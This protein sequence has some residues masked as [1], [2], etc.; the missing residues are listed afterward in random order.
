MENNTPVII[1]LID[2]GYD[3]STYR[4]EPLRMAIKNDNREVIQKLLDKGV[5]PNADGSQGYISAIKEG[6]LEIIKL[7]INKEPPTLAILSV[8]KN[9][10]NTEI[11]QE[12]NQSFRKTLAR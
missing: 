11:A 5:S 9:S 3:F 6:R 7:F 1:D 10:A 2:K 8:V 4:N 12:I